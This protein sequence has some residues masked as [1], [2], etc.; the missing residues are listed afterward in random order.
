M[1]KHFKSFSLLLP[2]VL[3]TSSC[4][5]YKDI[6]KINCYEDGYTH[7]AMYQNE[8]GERSFYLYEH[9]YYINGVPSLADQYIEISTKG[10]EEN[11][12]GKLS[13][14]IRYSFSEES[15]SLRKDVTY[16]SIHYLQGVDVTGKEIVWRDTAGNSK[17]THAL[18]M[19][20]EGGSIHYTDTIDLSSYRY[21][22]YD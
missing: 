12:I 1:A 18:T 11:K 9:Y 14:K 7:K 22:E 8:E 2:F 13:F 21:F 15:K 4:T 6:T 16:S 19:P 5:S 3:L 10:R 20:K 17:S